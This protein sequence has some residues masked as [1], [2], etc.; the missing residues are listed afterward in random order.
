MFRFCGF[1]KNLTIV[2]RGRIYS[3]IR[4][5]KHTT[6]FHSKNYNRGRKKLEGKEKEN[7]TFVYNLYLRNRDFWLDSEEKNIREERGSSRTHC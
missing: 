3:R 2:I 7:T 4:V 1:S 6:N 5:E